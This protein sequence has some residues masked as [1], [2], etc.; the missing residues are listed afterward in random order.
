MH[1]ARAPRVGGFSSEGSGGINSSDPPFKRHHGHQ[2]EAASAASNFPRA[3]MGSPTGSSFSSD[4]A[5]SSISVKSTEVF[6]FATVRSVSNSRGIQVT[7]FEFKTPVGGDVCFS[8]FLGRIK[9]GYP[10]NSTDTFDDS[11][12]SNVK[13]FLKG[14]SILNDSEINKPIRPEALL[15]KIYDYI[16]DKQHL[17]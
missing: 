11:F 9:M 7:E 13:F 10:L 2:R 14:T 16:S 8:E 4:S 1:R 3:K 6:E 15:K 12:V 17:E 5:V